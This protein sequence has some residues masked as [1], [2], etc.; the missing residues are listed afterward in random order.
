MLR[1]LSGSPALKRSRSGKDHRFWSI[2]ASSDVRLII[3]GTENSLLLC[4]V[5]NHEIAYHWGRTAEAQ[6][7]PHD[8]SGTIC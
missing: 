6:D 7:P 3:H 4:Y 8:W 1:T 5:D 2:R